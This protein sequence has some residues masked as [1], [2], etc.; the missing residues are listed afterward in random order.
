MNIDEVDRY[1]D[2]ISCI[3][4]GSHKILYQSADG[5]LIEDKSCG[6]AY[7]MCESEQSAKA[8]FACARESISDLILHGTQLQQEL[9]HQRWLEA[10]NPYYYA[11]YK[12]QTIQKQQLPSSLTLRLLDETR[13]EEVCAL[14]SYRDLAIPSYIS[15]R[16][17]EGMIGA[18]LHEELVGFIGTHD[19]GS[20]GLLEVVPK[21]RRN[22][23]AR[24]LVC[25]CIDQ[26]LTKGNIPYAE[27]FT[28]NEASKQL[29]EQV[30]MKISKDQLLWCTRK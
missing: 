13:I 11:V 9:K 5:I 14:Y 30:G 28:D 17:Q 26:Q 16:I 27:I 20:I 22:G 29:A 19:S 1:P 23:I 8:I 10:G 6:F 25:A 24:S 7:A 21:A 4:K 2:I 12:K 3:R 15:A 18:F